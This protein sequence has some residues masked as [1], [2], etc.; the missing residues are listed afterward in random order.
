MCRISGIVNSGIPIIELESVVRK[1]CNLQQHGGP[2]DEGVYTYKESNL[3][4]GNRRLA[5]L[6]LTIAGHQ[7]MTYRNYIITYNG[8]LYNFLS[9]KKELITLGHQFITETDTEV[10]LAAF[11]QWNTQS[12]ARFKGMFA[13]AL[14]DKEK[15]ALYL[16]RDP[17]G[18]KPLYYSTTSGG[19]CFASEITAFKPVPF[20]KENNAT[21]P[22]YLM[23]YGHIP[24]PVTTIVGVKP[25]HKGCFLKYHLNSGE[26]NLQSFSHYS[27]SSTI[28]KNDNVEQ[29]IH[30]CLD[31]AVQRHMLADAP[32][33]V[34]LSGGLDSG[35]IA[36]LAA[37]H[38]QSSLNTLSIYFDEPEYSEKKYQDL[39]IQ[40]LH[41]RQHQYLLE[42]STFHK[43]F[44]AILSAMDMPSCDGVNTWF[45]SKYARQQG[46]KAVLSGIGGDELFGGYPSFTRIR[47]ALLLQQLPSLATGMGGRSKYKRINRMAYLG[48]EG[49]KG[50]YL[51]LRGHFSPF[52][53]AKQLGLYENEVWKLLAEDPVLPDIYHIDP[54]NQAS[55]MEFNLYMQNQL[56]RD[57]DVMSM[58]HGI[59]IRV[60]FMDDDLIRLAYKINTS[61]KYAGPLP[62]QLLID[63]FK[64]ELP[65]AIWDRPKMGFSF[66][67]AQWLGA[68]SY[69]KDL[70]NNGNNKSRDAYNKFINGRMHWSHLMSLLIMRKRGVY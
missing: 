4:L 59:E 36:T 33:G 50:I 51:F 54:Q 6:D 37:K 21:W 68:S 9:L 34:F 46:L 24:E 47:K 8:E 22:V 15:K 11:A 56:L 14:L 44:P 29:L 13:F 7:P 52:Q 65:A 43:E 16:V 40:R 27:Y 53:I 30:D 20:L 48:M 19:I 28:Y 32:V 60:P 42:E 58:K 12:F 49:I 26:Y 18:I 1:M 35:I 55:W 2:D 62:K 25:L 67:F 57:A 5:L 38:R 17:A 70:M 69:V 64:N 39:M 66:P 23:A 41:C 3:V 63:S 10:I 31:N 61:I 45:I